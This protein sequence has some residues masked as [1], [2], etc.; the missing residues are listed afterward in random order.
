[1]NCGKSRTPK[2]ARPKGFKK[3]QQLTTKIF[4]AWFRF[5]VKEGADE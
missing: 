3:L 2:A 1:M 4:V 5:R